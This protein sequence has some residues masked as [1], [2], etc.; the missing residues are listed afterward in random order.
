MGTVLRLAELL[1]IESA[2]DFG[3][4]RINRAVLTANHRSQWI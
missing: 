3:L 2:N 1:T 4:D